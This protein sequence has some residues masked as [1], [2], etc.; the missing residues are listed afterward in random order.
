MTVAYTLSALIIRESGFVCELS[1]NNSKAQ[2]KYFYKAMVWINLS[3][4]GYKG[5]HIS[6]N[7][8][9]I[10]KRKTTKKDEENN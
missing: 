2:Q 8:H 5:H 7:K 3:L 4:Y 6:N 10:K 1:R 9:E